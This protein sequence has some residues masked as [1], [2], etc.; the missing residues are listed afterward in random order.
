M[1]IA[2]L[3]VLRLYCV[4]A[5]HVFRGSPQVLKG[6]LPTLGNQKPQI[7]AECAGFFSAY[8]AGASPNELSP[9]AS[10]FRSGLIGKSS[11]VKAEVARL[12]ATHIDSEGTSGDVFQSLVG[13]LVGAV[14][15]REEATR[16][17]V[18][19]ALR[20]LNRYYPE[21]TRAMGKA[22]VQQRLIDKVRGECSEAPSSTIP[23]PT[24]TRAK[25]SPFPKTK[26]S[27]KHR[28][29]SASMAS[30]GSR[31]S[32]TAEAEPDPVTNVSS[33]LSTIVHTLRQTTS[34]EWEARR[35]AL[36]RLG[37]V[38]V[39][40]DP[41]DLGDVAD[42]VSTI[43]ADFLQELGSERT[44]LASAAHRALRRMIGP[45]SGDRTFRG[46]VDTIVPSLLAQ[47]GFTKN[48]AS[49]DA[50]HSLNTIIEKGAC[51][52]RWVTYIADRAPA[53]ETASIPIRSYICQALG[54]FLQ[55]GTGHI[56]SIASAT[57]A[58]I[59]DRSA[60]V[61]DEAR[62]LLAQLIDVDPDE[63]EPILRGMKPTEADAYRRAIHGAGHHGPRSAESTLNSPLRSTASS[64]QLSRTTID[65]LTTPHHAAHH[66]GR[67]HPA[68]HAEAARPPSEGSGH[69]EWALA[70]DSMVAMLDGSRQ[71]FDELHRFI[72]ATDDDWTGPFERIAERLLALI[73]ASTHPRA[74]PALLELVT[75]RGCPSPVL[76]A[77]AVDVTH[78]FGGADRPRSQTLED[79]LTA[80]IDVGDPVRL[81]LTFARLVSDPHDRTQYMA[82]K[83]LGAA[84]SRA[85]GDAAGHLDAI[86]PDLIQLVA[87]R[88]VHVRKAAVFAIVEMVGVLGDPVR[89]RLAGLNSQ[90]LKVID[91]FVKRSTRRS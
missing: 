71:A 7:R 52:P 63:G 30:V 70:V 83:F 9:V 85:G 41:G 69:D 1:S 57:R 26:G 2:A 90:Q 51:K 47:T 78:A 64:A 45:L 56:D 86:M 91:T 40:A 12:I 38:A 3:T 20:A 11:K 6:V 75:V 46:F 53:T 74:F 5:P 8:M 81:A 84:M 60:G 18:T 66:A 34:T 27:P 14:G 4:F 79:L 77:I 67:P 87:A 36:L 54:L 29:R 43:G 15:D 80:L 89:D 23:T 24:P 62:R 22:G 58:L 25:P 13:P 50:V 28:V 73:R 49:K 76:D 16:T 82:A 55:H 48:L 33:E 32:K 35:A 19:D 72:H 10:C 65:H 59:H 39:A 61:R 21:V 68:P 88:H 44:M 31:F 42:A 17:N 37:D